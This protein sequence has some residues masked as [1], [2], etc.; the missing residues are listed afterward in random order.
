MNNFKDLDIPKKARLGWYV[1]VTATIV[2]YL[3]DDGQIHTGTQDS[4]YNSSG[5]FATE[6]EAH[7]AAERYY[8]NNC[9]AYPYMATLNASQ[10]VNEGSRVMNFWER[11]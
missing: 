7:K 11:R 9:R 10:N 1:V 8:L 5:Y 2:K 3:H 6:H 4:Y